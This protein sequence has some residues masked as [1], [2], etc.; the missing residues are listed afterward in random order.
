MD[1]RRPVMAPTIKDGRIPF[2][3]ALR[4]PVCGGC[5]DDPRGQ[6]V[7]CFGYLLDDWIHCSREEH[8]GHAKYDGD[9][10]RTYSHLAKGDCPCGEQHGPAP[11]RLGRHK[12]RAID[13]VYSY[14]DLQGKIRHQTIRYKPKDFFQRRPDGHGGYVY[15]DVF[16]GINPILYKWPELHAADLG[17]TVFIVEGEKD[18]ERLTELG[19]VATTNPMGAM[20]WGMVD[21]TPLDG[22][23]CVAIAD[24]DDNGRKHVQQI[25]A[26]RYGKSAWVKTLELPGLPEKGD[27]SDWLDAGHTVAELLELAEEAPQWSPD[28]G[29][30]PFHA[31]NGNGNA[32]HALEPPMRSYEA[33]NALTDEELGIIRASTIQIEAINWL[34]QYRLAAGE[35]AMLAGEPGLGKTQVMLAI[36]AAITTGSPWP[37]GGGNAPMG[38][39]I[40]LSAEDSPKTTIVPRLAAMN[41]DLNRVVILRAKAIRKREGKESLILPMSFQDLDWWRVVFDREKEPRILIA[42]P[43]VSYL[44][45]GVNDQRNTEIREILEPFL[46][47]I[48]RPRGIC[49]LGNTHLNK[50][51]DSRS[52]L[53][54]ISGSTAY[55]ALPRNV[56]FVVKDPDDPKVRYLKQCKSNNA[57][58]DLEAIPFK[59]IQTSVTINQVTVETSIPEFAAQGVDL[60]LQRVLGGDK[61]RRGPRPVKTNQ[62][63]KWVFE[64]LTE[65]P[66]MM[67][68][69]VEMAQEA[70]HIQL[71]TER[72]PK[73]S[74]AIL[75][76][77]SERLPET[78]PG[79]RVQETT[80]E[81]GVG[82]GRKPRKR[83]ELIQDG[84]DPNRPPY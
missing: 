42:D 32:K 67:R 11:L 16:K 10:A 41:A 83:W 9:E 31:G 59:L 61:G 56:H 25:A 49:F 68:D 77:A 39:V 82:T 84:D 4:C 27:V 21:S 20:K 14:V 2:T 40:I 71:P 78:Y 8:A 17:R 43:I 22:R 3:R 33:L 51:I 29:Y 15:K 81:A 46:E 19:L 55:G 30:G 38:S 58:D 5:R 1:E 64:R 48:I 53:N 73:P 72:R 69:L 66:L 70:G 47:D 62:V 23:P 74:I 35:F 80:V 18:V 60:D 7:R 24:N 54:R 75:Y 36:A 50:S 28:P 65:S 79:Y 45:K 34:W 57:P 76:D 13:R 44:G 63:V 26:D 52:P 12:K 37:G 6:G